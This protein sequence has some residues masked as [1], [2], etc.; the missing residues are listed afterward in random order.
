M[1]GKFTGEHPC[2]SAISIKLQSKKSLSCNCK[3]FTSM[4]NS[5]FCFLSEW[6][7][8]T[9]NLSCISPNSSWGDDL[10]LSWN[11][12]KYVHPISCLPFLSV[13][14]YFTMNDEQITLQWNYLNL[15]RLPLCFI[16]NFRQVDS[17]KKSRLVQNQLKWTSCIICCESSKPYDAQIAPCKCSWDFKSE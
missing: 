12:T 15:W 1:C 11:W 5:L 14:C 10:L 6:V 3:S 7:F 13:P 16:E 17:C 2:R 8:P 4:L 9:K